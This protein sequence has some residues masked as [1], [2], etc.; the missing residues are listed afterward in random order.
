MHFAVYQSDGGKKGRE[1]EGTMAGVSLNS[2]SKRVVAFS[3]CSM[4]S[5]L[6][7]M[8][9]RLGAAVLRSV[10]QLQTL[11]LPVLWGWAKGHVVES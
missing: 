7:Q 10:L 11:A 5:Q 8:Q 6:W 4:R 3:L 1:S 9:D 2:Q